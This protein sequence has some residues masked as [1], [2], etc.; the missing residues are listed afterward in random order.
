MNKVTISLDFE[1]GWGVLDSE[2][3]CRREE[4]GLYEN[5]R[6]KL[7]LVF[8]SLADREVPTTWATVAGMLVPPLAESRLDH[9]PAEYKKAVV[10]FQ[11]NAKR[12]TIDAR[13]IVDKHWSRVESFSE[14]ASHTT[15]HIYPEFPG[16]TSTCYREDVS[17]SLKI[18]EQ[19]FGK[20]VKS[21]VFTR[22]DTTFLSSVAG[23]CNLN[24][25]TECPAYGQR[26]DG[27]ITRIAK[28]C[29]RYLENVPRSTVAPSMR[30]STTQSGSLYFN[31]S[32]GRYS[33]LK[34]VQL[35]VQ[36][37]RLLRVLSSQVS[38]DYHIWLH[39]F[40][41]AETADHTSRF[42]WF[43]DRLVALRDAGQ[44]EIVTMSGFSHGIAR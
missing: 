19:Y 43:I 2:L 4:S 37:R 7:D 3:W 12:S 40:N 39:P 17:L 1:L 8:D 41:L 14:I 6:D 26:N 28:G 10:A 16:V 27:S 44:I 21:M 35:E 15:T 9:L 22:D 31:W 25:R 20:T 13:D 11:K 34:K 29:R 36:V 33:V 5:L 18:L 24:L 32:G 23:I 42:L 38:G 30:G